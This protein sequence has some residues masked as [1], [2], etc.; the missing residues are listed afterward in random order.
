MDSEAAKRT[1]EFR[2]NT[3]NDLYDYFRKNF[4][5]ARKDVD[6][7]IHAVMATFK[8]RKGRVIRTTELWQKVGL[9]LEQ[10]HPLAIELDSLD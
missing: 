4:S 1:E 5:L 10:K 6:L 2:W 7:E 3:R 8:P 9:T